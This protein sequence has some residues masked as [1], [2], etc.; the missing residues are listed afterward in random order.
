MSVA[1]TDATGNPQTVSVNDA[2]GTLNPGDAALVT[3][4]P[5]KITPRY[6]LEKIYNPASAAGVIPIAV[7]NN[8]N[9]AATNPKPEVIVGNSV[10]ETR[11]DVLTYSGLVGD[12]TV[13]AQSR[14]ETAMVGCSCDFSTAPAS[15]STIRGFRPAYWEGTRYSV[16]DQ[17]TY[18]PKA[19]EKSGATQSAKCSICCRDHHDPIGTSGPTFAPLRVTKVSGAVTAVHPHY[20]TTNGTT[21]TVSTTGPYQDACRLIRSDGIFRVAP[22]LNNDYFGLLATGDGTSAGTSV[23]DT[24]SVDGTPSVT[25]AVARYQKYVIGYLTGRFI[26]PTPTAGAAQATY[27]TVNTSAPV[28]SPPSTYPIELAD[29]APYVLTHPVSIDIALINTTGKWLHSRGLYI[30]YLEQDAVDAISV[31]K[32]D[33]ACTATQT[34]LSICIL[35]LL[36]FTTIN[37]TEVADWAASDATRMAVTNN[38]FSTSLASTDPVRG[39]VT[40]SASTAASPVNATSYSRSSNT[41]LLDLSF[42]SISANDDVKATSVQAFNVTGGPVG[43]TQYVN[44]NLVLPDPY[45]SGNGNPACSD[46]PNTPNTPAVTFLEQSAPATTYACNAPNPANGTVAKS[47]GTCYRTLT[48]S[49][50]IQGTGPLS[51]MGAANGLGIQAK[52][53]NYQ[54]PSRDTANITGC[55]YNGPNP[56]S[57]SFPTQTYNPPNGVD[58]AI[59]KCYNFTVSST[60]ST[61]GT[62]AVQTSVSDGNKGE[63]TISNFSLL[64]DGNS[65]TFNFSGPTFVTK[66]PSCTYTCTLNSGQTACAN[67]TAG[68]PVFSIGLTGGACP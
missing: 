38:D 4:K 5:V 18:V 43:G 28:N 40:T 65:V 53:Y 14:V 15:N 45:A 42:N 27:N 39:K 21:W 8:S 9:S 22:D 26:T 59:N 54:A 46:I 64:N 47:G 19:G 52:N 31:A 49:C 56:N 6:A 66:P 32:S 13:T 34:A 2:V 37:L 36:P 35:K 60:T 33:S 3:K 55:T 16:P 63:S 10:V 41:G 24:T 58:Y 50:P 23:P 61:A 20:Y 12:T 25:G 7:G 30:D 11:F 67:G 29:T 17:A 68:N 57:A 44:V 62:S 48:M 51:K 1:W